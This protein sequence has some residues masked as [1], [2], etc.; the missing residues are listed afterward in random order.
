M[1]LPLILDEVS[2]AE[3]GN[4]DVDFPTFVV[5]AAVVATVVVVGPSVHI[6]QVCQ[7][8]CL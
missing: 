8:N 6:T 1:I 5:V 3:S 7:R 2:L 4:C